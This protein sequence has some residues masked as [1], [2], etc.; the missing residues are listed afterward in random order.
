MKY[1]AGNFALDFPE[2]DEMNLAE[3]CER[4]IAE[5]DEDLELFFWEDSDSDWDDSDSDWDEYFAEA[6]EFWQNLIDEI[7]G[8]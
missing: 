8:Q 7:D 2:L 3:P 6:E 4:V 1:Y 5:D